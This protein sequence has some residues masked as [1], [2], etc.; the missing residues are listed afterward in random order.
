MKPWGNESSFP[1]A[2]TIFEGQQL[3]GQT[4]REDRRREET[5]KRDHGRTYHR[6]EIKGATREQIQ[7]DPRIRAEEPG[8]LRDTTSEGQITL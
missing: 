8:P 3:N 2:N 7:G 6:R 1:R 5:E 4:H